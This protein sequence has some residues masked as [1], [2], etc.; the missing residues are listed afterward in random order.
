MLVK[1]SVCVF[2]NGAQHN[3]NLVPGSFRWVGPRGRSCPFRASTLWQG[4]VL[5]ILGTTTWRDRSPSFRN[6]QFSLQTL[7]Q[8]RPRGTQ[9]SHGLPIPAFWKMFRHREAEKQ[10]QEERKEVFKCSGRDENTGQRAQLQTGLS[11][12]RC[13]I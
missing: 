11:C 2:P 3:R 5:L 7:F 13:D 4:L 10:R 9:C 12:L 1:P 6:K 8:Q